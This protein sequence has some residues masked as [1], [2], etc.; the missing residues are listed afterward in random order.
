[1]ATHFLEAHTITVIHKRDNGSGI[2]EIPIMATTTGEVDTSIT[3]EMMAELVANFDAFPVVP[4]GVSPHKE[5]DERGGFSLAF[6]ESIELR[7]DELFGRVDLIAPLFAEVELGGWR[8]FSVE[9]AHN[10]KTQAKDIPGWTLTGG[11]FTNRPAVDAHFKIAAEGRI[12]SEKTGTYSSPLIQGAEMAEP[13]ATPAAK[14]GDERVISLELHET[15]LQAAADRTVAQAAAT[16]AAEGRLELANDDN[17]RLRL[18]ASNAETKASDAQQAKLEAEAK[19]NRLEAESR[20]LKTANEGLKRSVTELETQIQDEINVNLSARVLAVRDAAIEAGVPP[21]MFD[22]IDAD[23]GTWMQGQFASV[24][25][26]EKHF[27]ALSG[28]SR[29]LVTDPA[30]SGHDPSK[31]SG[32]HP[33]SDENAAKLKRMGLDVKFVGIRSESELLDLQAAEDSKKN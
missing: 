4:V 28:V 33:V 5:F 30:Q 22:G 10:L 19:S 17:K 18:E 13:N 1:M 9:I 25:A 11:V 23:P 6:I 16:A 32:E 8:G 26:Y 15:K 29:D 21:R 7:G 24:E 12:G 20:G 14:S 2:I 27:T 31:G 3:V